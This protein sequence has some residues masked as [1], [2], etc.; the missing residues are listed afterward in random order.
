MVKRA[1]D[2]IKNRSPRSLSGVSVRVF[3][4]IPAVLGASP[5]PRPQPIPLCWG[6]AVP[7]WGIGLPFPVVQCAAAN[8]KPTP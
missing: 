8:T 7:A 3:R 1:T 6:P 5:A 2:Y 4:G